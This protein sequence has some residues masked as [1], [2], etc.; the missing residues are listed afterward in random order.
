MTVNRAPTA[1]ASFPAATDKGRA[2]TRQSALDLSA[3]NQTVFRV[4]AARWHKR[5]LAT[6]H[7]MTEVDFF[8]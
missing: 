1:F 2:G 8:M 3:V 7:Y 6:I 5:I 4:T